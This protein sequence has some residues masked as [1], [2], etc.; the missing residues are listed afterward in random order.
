[1]TTTQFPRRR[2]R[3][4]VVAMVL[5]TAISALG[6]TPTVQA[7]SAEITRSQ[8]DT[9]TRYCTACWRNAHLPEHCW[10]DCTHEV[11][12]RLLE[13]LDPDDWHRLLQRDSEQRRELIR[14]I[15]AV[16]KR[17]IRERH[18]VTGLANAVVDHRDAHI[19]RRHE[20]REVVNHAAHS[21]LTGRQRQILNMSFDGWSVHDISKSLDLPPDRVSDEKYKAIRK[22]QRHF[23]TT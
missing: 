14:A 1:M 5:G 6:S 23:R 11:F 9:L 21:L 19:R 15:D 22:L 7:T 8:V 10:S 17:V 16:K 20:T 12:C 2:S 13:R 3:Q 4:Y 18:R